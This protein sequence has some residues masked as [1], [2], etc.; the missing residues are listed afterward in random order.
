MSRNPEEVLEFY[1]RLLACQKEIITVSKSSVNPFF[2]SKYAD[3]NAFLDATKKVLNDHGLILTQAHET[4]ELGDF[5]VTRISYYDECIQSKT[6][7]IVSKQ[8][9]PQ[10][11]G[12]AITYARRFGLQ[13]LLALQAEDDDGETA[14]GRGKT[15]KNTY[16]KQTG[17]P[18]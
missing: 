3:I 10:A 16:G 13:S 9:D 5:V 11:F 18:F 4:S 6:R 14:M 1:D 17:S 12:A 7:I 2:N 15:N 8:N